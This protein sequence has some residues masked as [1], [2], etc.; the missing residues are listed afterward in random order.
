[1]KSLV[2]SVMYMLTNVYNKNSGG[3]TYRFYVNQAT[4]SDWIIC[5][6]SKIIHGHPKPSDTSVVLIKSQSMFPLKPVSVRRAPWNSPRIWDHQVSLQWFTQ[7]SL[8]HTD[9]HPRSNP[10]RHRDSCHACINTTRAAR[11]TCQSWL[12]N[13]R[14]TPWITCGK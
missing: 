12:L 9:L 8:L 3:L 1:M 11:T 4:V 5:K 2:S 14:Q 13:K 6:S 7:Y 10:H